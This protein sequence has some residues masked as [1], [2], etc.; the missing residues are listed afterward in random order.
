M[1]VT[2]IQDHQSFRTGNS[3][4]KRGDEATFARYG[5]Q[6]IE[7]D[8]VIEGWGLKEVKIAVF[9]SVEGLVS[10]HAEADNNPEGSLD[11]LTVPELKDL[12]K[13]AAVPGYSQMKKAGL[14]EALS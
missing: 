4:Y 8:V 6:L 7:L 14:I 2:F 9:D 5:E 1:N 10:A 13:A 11:D 3:A 12:A